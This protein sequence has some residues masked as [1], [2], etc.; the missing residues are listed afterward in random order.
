[1]WRIASIFLNFFKFLCSLRTPTGQPRTS[2]G[3]AC[4]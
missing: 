1:V 3:L 4:L 2:N